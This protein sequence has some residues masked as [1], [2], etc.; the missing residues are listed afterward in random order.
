MAAQGKAQQG[1]KTPAQPVY[2]VNAK[3][4]YAPRPNTA[5]NNVH[6]W[7]LLQQHLAKNGAQTQAQLQ[8]VLKPVN[9]TPFVQYCIRRGWLVQQ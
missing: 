9:H 2:I 5:Q 1:A 7:G 3:Q 6:S 8:A 4:P